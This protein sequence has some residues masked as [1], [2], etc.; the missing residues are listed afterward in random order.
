MNGK[1]WGLT[2]LTVTPLT[3][4]TGFSV[5]SNFWMAANQPLRLGIPY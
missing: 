5:A 3:A 2:P 1:E 4:L